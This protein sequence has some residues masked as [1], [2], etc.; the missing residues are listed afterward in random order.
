MHAALREYEQQGEAK[1]E[2]GV[3]GGEHVAAREAVGGVAGEWEQQ[4]ARE[5]LGEAD[6]AEIERP[7][8][9][10]VD[11]PAHGHRLHFDGDN[12]EKPRNLEQ[13]ERRMSEGG[14]SGSGVGGCGHE[15]LMCHRTRNSAPPQP[16][17]LPL[18]GFTPRRQRGQG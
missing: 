1:R 3:A 9:D 2:S 6:V 11:L 15:L 4:N 18:P 7:L 13:D 5:K 14:A 12:D 17:I 10:F 8:S 16:S